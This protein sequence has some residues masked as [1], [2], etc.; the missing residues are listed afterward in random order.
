MDGWNANRFYFIR[1]IKPLG[2]NMPIISTTPTK[3]SPKTSK[4]VVVPPKATQTTFVMN[5]PKID[6]KEVEEIYIG[7]SGLVYE[8]MD[9]QYKEGKIS[10]ATYSETWKELMKAVISGSLDSVV[11][12][13]GKETDSDRCLKQAQCKEIP[14][15]SNREERLT[16]AQ[17]DE[18]GKK[19]GREERLAVS[20]IDLTTEKTN[21]EKQKN[22]VL[23]EPKS[24]YAHNVRILE[25]QEN[26][27]KRQE[28]GFNDNAR[29]KYYDSISK[30]YGIMFQDMQLQ[31]LPTNMSSA[32]VGGTGD[33]V[34]SMIGK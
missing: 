31:T 13:L 33:Q 20:Q 28:K 22:G 5:A 15:K 7:L 34:F 17:I 12:L 29:Q 6:F 14:L 2:A 10:G 18:I 9:K 30:A 25:A 21:A 24:L 19:S 32:K 4:A 11:A 23:N 27:Y 26:L 3:S 1:S 8:D 16:V